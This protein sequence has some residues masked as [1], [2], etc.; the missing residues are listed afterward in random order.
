[1][2]SPALPKILAGLVICS[3]GQPQSIKRRIS[4]SQRQS[5]F[6]QI[7]AVARTRFESIVS[8]LLATAVN[9]S[10]KLLVRKSCRMLR[11]HWAGAASLTCGYLCCSI[12]GVKAA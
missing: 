2:E 7:F 5:S 10:P 4:A 12:L 6:V 11:T 1:M 3:S 8:T 9:Y